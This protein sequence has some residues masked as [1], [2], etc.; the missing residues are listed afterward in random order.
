MSKKKNE[1]MKKSQGEKPV[2]LMKNKASQPVNIY[3]GKKNLL[4]DNSSAQQIQSTV[5]Q[6]DSKRETLQ[7]KNK[8]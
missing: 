5:H 3:K 1:N 4:A 7:I 8:V 6:E 2:Y